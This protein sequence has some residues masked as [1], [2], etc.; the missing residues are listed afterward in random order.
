MNTK[1]QYFTQILEKLGTPLLHSVAA[2]VGNQAS[3]EEQAKIV[4]ELLSRSVQMSIEMGQSF[5]FADLSDHGDSVRVALATLAGPLVAKQYQQSGRMPTEAD[6]KKVTT[7][8]QSV[9]T[10]SE[11]FSP[12]VENAQR[13]ADLKAKGEAVDAAQ[14]DLQYIEAFVPVVQAVSGFSFGQPENKLALDIADRLVKRAVEMREAQFSHVTNSDE[15]KRI[16]VVIA[17]AQADLYAAC[18]RAVMDEAIKAAESGG[19]PPGIEAV[20]TQFDLRSAMLESLVQGVLGG[21]KALVS[22]P[23]SEVAP[24]DAPAPVVPETSAPDSSA[25]PAIFSSAPIEPDVVIETAKDEATPA[26]FGGPK[27]AEEVKEEPPI[28]AVDDVIAP[29]SAAAPEVPPAESSTP[30]NPMA[31][32]ATPKAE[33]PAEPPAPVQAAPAEAAASPSETPPPPAPPA[34]D[35]AEKSDEGGEEEGDS[36]NPMSFFGSGG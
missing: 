12:S 5:N 14:A 33:E 6:L 32:F 28:P 1:E 34:K 31:M 2:S 26:I 3:D 25:A 21:D 35:E 22:K 24:I 30:A 11:N 9:L 13:I 27:P 7:V 8:L 36:K 19:T 18:H 4:A 17:G 29:A 23:V 16:E 20:W 15:Q 10:F